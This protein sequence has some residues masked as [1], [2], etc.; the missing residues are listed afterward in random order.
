MTD[1]ALGKRFEKNADTLESTRRIL[2]D[3]FG[4]RPIVETTGK[5]WQA[6]NDL[7]HRLPKGH[8]KSSADKSLS[9]RAIVANADAKQRRQISAANKKIASHSLEG[10]QKETSSAA[11]RSNVFHPERCSVTNA[12]YRRF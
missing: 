6:L 3:V 2:T 9:Y 12:P 4:N 11:P 5:D 8:G 10:D 1:E 7:L